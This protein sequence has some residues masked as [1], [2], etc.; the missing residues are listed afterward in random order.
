MTQEMLIMAAILVAVILLTFIGILSRYRKCK[1]DEVLV[2]YGKTGGEK[3]SAK[4]YHGGAAFVWPI[5]QGYEFLSM[6]PMQ[7]DC[8]LTGALSAQNIRVDVPTTITVA[9]STDAE[10]M[11]NAAERMLGLTMNDKQNLI[12]DVVYGQMRLVIA[13]MTIE[14]LNSDRDK[15]LSKVKDNIDTELRKFG[16]YLM[17]INISDIRDAANY[18]V[19]LGKEAESK[20]QNEA[21]ANIEEQEKLGAIKIATQ[22]KERETKV[23]ETRKDQDIAIAETKKLQE[24]SVA[25]ADKDRISQVAIANAEK[26]AQVAKAEAEKNIRIE[27]ANTEKESRIAELNSDM[28]IKQAEAGKKAAIGRN[29][30]QKEVALSNSELAVTQANADKQ[31]GEAA[32]R[33][34]A[35]VQAAREI[36]QKEVEEAKAKKVESSLKAEKIVPA[37]IARQEAILQANAIAEKITREAEARAKATLAQAE[38]EA[39]AIQLKLEAEAEG[40]KKSL[41]AEAEGFEAMVRA[42]E[43]NPAIAI[44]YKMVDQWKEIAG[45]QVKAFE[46]MNLGNITVFDGGNGSTSNFLNTLVKTVAPS[47]G[48]LD[49]LPIG[50]TVKGIIHPE[51]KT[52]EKTEEKKEEK[53]K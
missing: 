43:S 20:A 8:K 33:S 52:E 32:A 39:R 37:E 40:K 22:I 48:V 25:N 45:E 31:A 4:L 23:A 47:L 44:Q 17:N 35:A 5:I 21:Q 7:I 41:L 53:K 38:A 34:E 51:N 3:K 6:K 14:E 18:I 12:T 30:A 10:V 26:E 1:S 49:K 27:Q 28:E 11:Q 24:I 29:E 9:I 36:A 42:A 50:E 16:L 2:V 13:D 19:N 15:F 46:H